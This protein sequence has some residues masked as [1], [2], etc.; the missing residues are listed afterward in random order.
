MFTVDDHIQE[1]YKE[2]NIIVMA[3]AKMAAE[4]GWNI[5]LGIDADA[6]GWPVLYIDSPAGQLSWHIHERDLVGNWADFTQPWDGHT[7]EQKLERLRQLITTD[8][9]KSLV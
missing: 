8:E 7:T 2:R 9:R 1:L 4:L 5:G 3:M 6:P